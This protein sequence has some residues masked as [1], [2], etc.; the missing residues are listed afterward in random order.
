M[1]EE[2]W[3]ALLGILQRQ[4]AKSVERTRGD[5]EYGHKEPL[6][7]PKIYVTGHSLGGSIAQLL[8]LD[9]AN[10]CELNLKLEDPVGDQHNSD[11][12]F[13]HIPM[14]TPTKYGPETLYSPIRTTSSGGLETRE[15][16]KLKPALCVYTYGQPRVGNHAFARIY[17]KAVPHTFR[18]AT[19][20][21][22]ITSTPTAMM[23]GGWYKHAGLEV[24]LDE[25][26]T[27]NILVGPTVVETMFRFTKM[28]T[29]LAA[30][31]L[32]TYRDALESG[33][34]QDELQEYYRTH[35]IA[36]TK[37]SQKRGQ[38]QPIQQ[39]LPGWLTTV[40]KRQNPLITNV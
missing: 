12:G 27:G 5:N 40:K 4:L 15:T 29:S 17:K 3:N 19:E 38:N 7:L 2:V 14:D 25:G 35:G 13:F 21:D 30:H 32:E 24:M 23:C 18:V 39:N 6:Y 20:G 11:D 31:S 28:R 34:T 8:A 22:A 37:A 1:R 36:R 16:I 9:L 26:L 10:N 33:L